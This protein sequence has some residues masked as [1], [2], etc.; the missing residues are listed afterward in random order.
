MASATLSRS[1]CMAMIKAPLACS[2]IA[3]IANT[4]EVKLALD[5]DIADI[6][7]A[8]GIHLDE[9]VLALS[10]T[11]LSLC[12]TIATDIIVAAVAFLAVRVGSAYRLIAY[13][14]IEADFPG[15]ILDKVGKVFCVLTVA[16]LCFAFI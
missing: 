8:L 3:I 16:L 6:A 1:T 14:T 2:P 5:R 13:I 7:V 10:I 4:A 15:G 9:A 12:K 11:G